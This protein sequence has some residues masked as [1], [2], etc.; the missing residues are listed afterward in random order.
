MKFCRKFIIPL[1]CLILLAQCKDSMKNKRDFDL[2]QISFNV[3]N[4]NIEKIDQSDV[5]LNRITFVQKVAEISEIFS[6]E[7]I[8]FVKISDIFIRGKNHIYVA[9][10]PMTV[11]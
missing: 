4:L 2:A 9:D 8:F 3:E 6:D 5:D 1:I 10:S 11:Y 7:E